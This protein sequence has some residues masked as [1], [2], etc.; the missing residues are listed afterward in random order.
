MVG[1]AV[2]AGEVVG[3]AQPVPTAADDEG[4]IGGPWL[5][6]AATASSSRAGPD[7]PPYQQRQAGEGL[8]RRSCWVSGLRAHHATGLSGDEHPRAD[9]IEW[10]ATGPHNAREL[11]LMRCQHVSGD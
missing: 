2:L 10:G 1:E 8:H 7:Q 3:R 11:V 4:V 5:G 9:P 6:S